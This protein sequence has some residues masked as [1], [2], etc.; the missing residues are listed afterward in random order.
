MFKEPLSSLSV[1]CSPRWFVVIYRVS[2][3]QTYS[4]TLKPIW[5]C[6]SPAVWDRFLYPAATVNT[7]WVSTTEICA[8]TL[9]LCVHIYLYILYMNIFRSGLISWTSCIRI[10]IAYQWSEKFALRLPFITGIYAMCIVNEPDV[11]NKHVMIAANKA[12]VW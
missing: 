7:V 8:N 6:L 3:S 11:F 12:M 9:D 2:H 4:R 10:H 5:S 1:V